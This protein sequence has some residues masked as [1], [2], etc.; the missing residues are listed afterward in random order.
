MVITDFRLGGRQG[1]AVVLA[2]RNTSPATPV[3]L[4]TGLVDELPRWMRAGH[5][6]LP[7]VPKPFRMHELLDAMKSAMIGSGMSLAMPG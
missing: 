7:I 6:A 3:V 4:V 1:D 5:L 2:A